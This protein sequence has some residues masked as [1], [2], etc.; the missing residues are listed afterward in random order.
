MQTVETIASMAKIWDPYTA[1]HQR[2]VTRLTCTQARKLGLA[3]DCIEG[4]RVAG[5]LHDI[6]KIV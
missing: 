3:N 2:G 5:F 4:I 6:G 1:G